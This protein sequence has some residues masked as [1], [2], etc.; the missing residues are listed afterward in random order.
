MYNK[1]KSKFR[2]TKYGV[3]FYANI[4]HEDIFTKINIKGYMHFNCSNTFFEIQF[5]EFV[6]HTLNCHKISVIILKK[7]I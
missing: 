1:K 4:I 6:V 2:G 3:T 7:W 5:K